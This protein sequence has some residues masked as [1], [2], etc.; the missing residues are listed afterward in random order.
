MKDADFEKEFNQII[1]NDP[2]IEPMIKNNKMDYLGSN[3][4]LKLK[5]ERAE[6]VMMDKIGKLLLKDVNATTL[7]MRDDYDET[8]FKADLKAISDEYFAQTQSNFPKELR[9]LLDASKD[10]TLMLPILQN[11]KAQ[12]QA[13]VKN[14][15]MH[16]QLLNNTT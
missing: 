10:K 7:E 15:R 1:A 3:I 11:W 13:N 9:D 5:Q 6:Q 8:K 14:L 12:L 2:I 16:L 4:L